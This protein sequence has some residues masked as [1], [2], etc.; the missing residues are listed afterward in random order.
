MEAVGIELEMNLLLL[1]KSHTGFISVWD[2]TCVKDSEP[3][4]LPKGFDMKSLT[5]DKCIQACQDKGYSYA[6]VQTGYQC[7]CGNQ[8]PPVDKIV[9]VDQMWWILEDECIFNFGYG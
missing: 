7:W 2:G 6:G 9:A 4:L 3:R 5:P 8:A 1:Y